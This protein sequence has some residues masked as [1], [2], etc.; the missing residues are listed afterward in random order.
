MTLLGLDGDNKMKFG[1]EPA[2]QRIGRDVYA[3]KTLILVYQ[4]LITHHAKQEIVF[5]ICLGAI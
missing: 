4:K 2:R 5:S 1:T 3:D